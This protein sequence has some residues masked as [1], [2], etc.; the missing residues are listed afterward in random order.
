M[1]SRILDNINNRRDRPGVI[2]LVTLV[3]LVVLATLGYSLSSRLS[4]QRHR[5]Q[6]MIDYSEA[7]YGC[8]SALKYALSTLE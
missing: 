6:Y 2:L 1:S 7:R 8:D 5:V 4:T 3:L